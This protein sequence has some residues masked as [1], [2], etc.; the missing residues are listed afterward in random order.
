MASIPFACLTIVSES[1][2][3]MRTT[4]HALQSQSLPSP[5]CESQRVY[6]QTCAQ[7]LSMNIL[8]DGSPVPGALYSTHAWCVCLSSAV[9]IDFSS[10][11][12]LFMSCFYTHGSSAVLD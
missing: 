12:A 8:A 4:S 9:W 11:D 1:L 2:M 7:R 6:V 10:N 5:A 3:H